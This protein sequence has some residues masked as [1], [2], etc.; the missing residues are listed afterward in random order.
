VEGRRTPPAAGRGPGVSPV[1]LPHRGWGAAGCT[2]LSCPW[3][4]VD[5][6]RP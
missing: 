3:A 2:S 5:V 1:C 4:A 6:A